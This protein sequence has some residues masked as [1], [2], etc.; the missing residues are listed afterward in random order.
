M[1]YKVEYELVLVQA[2]QD[3]VDDGDV[4]ADQRTKRAKIKAQWPHRAAITGGSHWDAHY[5]ISPVAENAEQ[6]QPWGT[7]DVRSATKGS[8][9]AAD[10]ALTVGEQY[11]L[12]NSLAICVNGSTEPW[13]FGVTKTYHFKIIDHHEGFDIVGLDSQ[14]MPYQHRTVQ[15]VAIAAITNNRACHSTEIGI[16]SKVYKRLNGTPN[17]NSQPPDHVIERYEKDRAFI[18]LGQLSIYVNRYSFFYL[19]ARPLGGNNWTTI[20]EGKVFAVKGRTTQAQYNYIRITHNYGQ[21]EFRLVPYAG[22]TF[23]RH[24]LGSTVFLLKPG[25]THTYT[26][27]GY[28]VTFSGVAVNLSGNDVS[29][30]E[31]IIGGPG[32][33]PYGDVIGLSSGQT[34]QPPSKGPISDE[35]KYDSGHQVKE[36][37]RHEWK[38]YW[39]RKSCWGINSKTLTVEPLH[40]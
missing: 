32:M 8:R 19:Q 15:R 10:E 28:T 23:Y 6:Y 39:E 18:S 1:K 27:H 7:E 37:D 33:V 21:Y 40:L 13:D 14:A 9:I 24:R 34:G 3:G 26:T 2:E 4:R 12:G 38:F 25:N 30:P 29:N 5:T 11:M 20:S 31:W 17:F 35:T 16:K 36:Y 22:N